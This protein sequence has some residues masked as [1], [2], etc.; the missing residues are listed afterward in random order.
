M[1]LKALGLNIEDMRNVRLSNALKRK[2][3]KEGSHSKLWDF[4][5]WCH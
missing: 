5:G 4:Q 2:Q 3:K 1:H